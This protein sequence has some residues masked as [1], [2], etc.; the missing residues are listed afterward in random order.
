M[1]QYANKIIVKRVDD[2]HAV[3]D[4][5]T[6]AEKR[7]FDNRHKL[8][9]SALEKIYM[10]DKRSDIVDFNNLEFITYNA[11]GADDLRHFSYNNVHFVDVIKFDGSY[12]LRFTA[13]IVK[14]GEDLIEEFY[15]E[16]AARKSE[17]HEARKEVNELSIEDAVQQMEDDNYDID[18]AEDL[19][20]ELKDGK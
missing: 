1:E 16:I 11:Y 17:N 10:G 8:F 12:V 13:D 2:T 5:Y 4:L 14:D 19:L 20:K 3:L 9:I 7:Q 18:Q 6:W 15:D